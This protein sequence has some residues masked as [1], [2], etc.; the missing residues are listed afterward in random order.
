MQPTYLPYLGYFH[1]IAASDVFVFLDDVQ[2]AR[3]SWQSRNRILG[4]GGEVMLTVPV[5]KHERDTPICEI[6]ISEAEP[7]RDKHLASIRHAYARRPFFAE[8]FTFLEEALA[9]RGELAGLNRGIVE[10]AAR[11]LGLAAE[12]VNASDLACPGHRSEHLLAICRA[13]GA[14]DYLSPMGSQ[15]YMV[16]DGVFTAAGFPVRFQGFVQIPYPQGREP[17]TPYMAFVDALMNLGWAGLRA[18]LGEM[19][20]AEA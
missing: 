12:F 8:G 6:L 11:R 7:W 15:D 2:F 10:A 16:E 14:T 13:V 3:R 1:L 20:E 5:Q 18:L 9:T 19:A 17:F 4:A